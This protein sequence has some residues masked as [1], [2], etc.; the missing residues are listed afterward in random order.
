MKSLLAFLLFLLF[1]LTAHAQS[2]FEEPAVT[3]M[4][5]SF[6]E[7][8]RANTQVRGW[9]IQIISTTDRRVM[10]DVQSRFKR[11]Y[12]E[13]ELLF[14]HQNPYY[15]LKT[16]AFLSQQD[17]RPLLKKLQ[18]DFPAAFMVSDEIQITEVL[19]YLN[20]NIE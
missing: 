6:I 12:P 17:A 20:N 1:S 11:R 16:G 4:M 9:R 7:Y 2:I 10:E 14:V 19:T 5:A 8:N 15:H 13:F 3:R 18:R